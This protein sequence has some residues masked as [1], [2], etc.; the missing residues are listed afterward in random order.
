MRLTHNPLPITH[1]GFLSGSRFNHCFE[2]RYAGAGH[3]PGSG[4]L[5]GQFGYGF[6]QNKGARL[7]FRAWRLLLQRIVLTQ[8]ERNEQADARR[9]NRVVVNRR[10]HIDRR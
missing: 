5:P 10:R 1:Y 9:L 8:M 6:L 3:A 4:I 7:G 2:T